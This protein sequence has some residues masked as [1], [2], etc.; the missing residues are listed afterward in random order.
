[1]EEEIFWIFVADLVVVS[2]SWR[3]LGW[4]RE[5]G[6]SSSNDDDDDTVLALLF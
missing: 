4:I 6:V 2:A 1:M 3:M 5:G